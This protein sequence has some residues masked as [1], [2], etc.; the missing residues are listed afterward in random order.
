MD[1]AGTAQPI[2]S[3]PVISNGFFDSKLVS[4]GTGKY[5]EVQ[6]TSVPSSV[7]NSFYTLLDK[8]AAVSSRSVLQA[9]SVSSSGT[10]TVPAFVY[11]TPP[12]TGTSTL[13]LGWYVDLDRS[14]GERQIS[15]ITGAFGQLFFGSLFPTKGSC[16][17]GGGKF[18]AVN[19]LTGNGTSELSRVGILAAPLILEIGNSAITNSDSSG[20]RTVTRKIAVITQG[21]KGLQVAAT[22]GGG[23]NYSQQVGRVSWRQLNNFQENKNN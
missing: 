2:S 5:L 1:S 9:G 11:G 17:E 22:S 14:I 23:L 18:Y 19:A 8:S 7:T 16:G 20:Q 12:A 21:S 3:E 13:K 6:D 10:V 4:F 15:D